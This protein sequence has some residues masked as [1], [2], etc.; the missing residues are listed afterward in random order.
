MVDDSFFGGGRSSSFFVFLSY[1]AAGG[2]VGFG[3]GLCFSCVQE[4][5]HSGNS[6]QE[7]SIWRL[8]FGSVSDTTAPF[9]SQLL[10]TQAQCWQRILARFPKFCWVWDHARVLGVLLGAVFCENLV[11]PCVFF[12]RF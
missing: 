7:D 9:K 5:A 11:L 4:E 12:N 10:L 3:C 6:N 1:L 8:I 2:R